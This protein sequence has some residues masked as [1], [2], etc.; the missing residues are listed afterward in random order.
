M[1]ITALLLAGCDNEEQKVVPDPIINVDTETVIELPP[2]GGSASFVYSIDNPVENGRLEA[3]PSDTWM[4]DFTTTDDEVRF[5]VEANETEEL[6]EGSVLLT[7]VYGEDKTVNAVVN[8]SQAVMQP[9]EEPVPTITITTED[10]LAL[11]ADGGSYTIEYEITDPAEDGSISADAGDSGWITDINCDTDGAIT[12]SV[13]ANDTEEERQATITVTY[14]YNGSE[15]VSESI[16]AVQEA[17]EPPA[18]QYDFEYEMTYREIYYYQGPQGMLNYY[19][20]IS[21][22]EAGSGG[23][24]PNGTAYYIFDIYADSD[25]SLPPAG[26]YT[27]TTDMADMTVCSDYSRV[28]ITETSGDIILDCY[29]TEGTVT[30]T[31]EDNNM[32][33]DAVLTDA[34]GNTHHVTYNGAT[35]D[36]GGGDDPEP[37]TINVEATTAL[38]SYVSDDGEIMNVSLQLTD[39]PVDAEGYVTPP[40]S[41]VAVDLYM[42]VDLSGEMV[43]GYYEVTDEYSEFTVSTGFEFYGYYMGTYVRVIDEMGGSEYQLI[44]GGYM[45]ISGNYGQYTI[46]CEFTTDEGL[47][48]NCNYSGALEVSNL[49]GPVSTLTGDYTLTMDGATAT[50]Y[51]YGD[52]YAN[53]T[54]NWM[55]NIDPAG[56]IGDGLAIELLSTPEGLEAGIPTGTYTAGNLNTGEF[57]AGEYIPGS[58]DGTYIYGTAYLEYTSIGITGLAPAISGDLNIT[59]NGDGTYEFSFEFV[60]DLGYTWDGTWSG[61]ISVND[62]SGGYYA[63]SR[64]GSVKLTKQRLSNERKMEILKNVP[65]IKVNQSVT[66]TMLKNKSL[67]F[68]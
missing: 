18:S 41:I 25:S 22:Q 20:S 19:M 61:A 49:P 11:A 12:F 45:D 65:A 63:P 51:Y 60:D 36:P 29:L 39:M 3:E 24:Y 62:E 8:V 68:R 64:T 47:T 46:K 66:P 33:L 57:N 14:T 26:T 55:I 42:P 44:T 31:Y 67:I 40:G 56:K 10:P 7:Y 1:A 16:E 54:D 5:R 21:D 52:Y 38:A 4:S 17:N 13:A 32:V 28:N 35:E 53:G 15:T 50:A 2:A 6:R 34:D 58:F 48:I 23:F 37:E 43:N 59:N 27:I 30:I 9:G